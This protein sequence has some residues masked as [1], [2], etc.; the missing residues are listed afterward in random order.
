MD[1]VWIPFPFNWARFLLLN[2]E[3]D[4]LM[5]LKDGMLMR[6][7]QPIKIYQKNLKDKVLVKK[8]IL[9]GQENYLKYQKKV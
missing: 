7:F 4:I 1:A 9:D 8:P 2:M 6:L 5:L 3:I